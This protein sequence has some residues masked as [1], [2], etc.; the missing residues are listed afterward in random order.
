MASIQDFSLRYA[1]RIEEALQQDNFIRGSKVSRIS[2]NGS[3]TYQEIL[4]IRQDISNLK[5]E[6][7]SNLIS[8]EDQKAIIE[9]IIEALNFEKS[10]PIYDSLHESVSVECASNDH[11]S[12]LGNTIEQILRD[13]K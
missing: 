5:Y 7:S 4:K 3:D 10:F 6:N 8:E 2:F 1:K 13:N 11:F 12:D 9:G